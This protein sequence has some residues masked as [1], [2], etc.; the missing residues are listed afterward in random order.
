MRLVVAVK[1]RIPTTTAEPIALV[2]P[3]SS[4]RTREAEEDV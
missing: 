2:N 4:L 1:I 3:E